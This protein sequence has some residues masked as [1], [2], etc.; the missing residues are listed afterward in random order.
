MWKSKDK[1]TFENVVKQLSRP[2][3]APNGNSMRVL[4]NR[5]TYEI[6][7]ERK[8][9]PLLDP[10]RVPPNVPIST[11]KQIKILSLLA[12]LK[13]QEGFQ[14]IFEEFVD[15]LSYYIFA[16]SRLFM[17]SL[18]QACFLIRFY[19]ILLRIGG[20]CSCILIANSEVLI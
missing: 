4:F 14:S 18:Y 8:E 9:D 3:F 13:E 10:S 5:I 16:K 2:E 6:M 19:V 15:H 1:I 11:A 20:L 17:M 7:S 12:S